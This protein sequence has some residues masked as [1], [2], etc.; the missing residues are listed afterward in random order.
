M[1]MCYKYPSSHPL[2][3]DRMP[4]E[5]PE[6]EYVTKDQIPCQGDGGALGHPL[7]WLK[8]SPTEGMVECPYCDK[9][10]IH[11]SRNNAP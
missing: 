8:I 2:F 4:I 3:E 10:F 11:T 9:Q 1:L 7:V 6:I 5:P